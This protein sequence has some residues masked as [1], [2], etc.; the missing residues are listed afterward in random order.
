[1][2]VAVAST[3][4]APVSFG[5]VDPQPPITISEIRVEGNTRADANLIIVACGLVEQR[6]YVVTE[7]HEAT[8]RAVRQLWTIGMFTDI[9]LTGTQISDT[10]VII[11][12]TVTE[13]PRLNTISFRGNHLLPGQ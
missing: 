7:F 4:I 1:M 10:E 12:I 11:T 3:L 13:R 2:A 8:S 9:Q 5:Q 6:P